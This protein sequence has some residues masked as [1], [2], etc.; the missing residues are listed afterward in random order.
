M[1]AGLHQDPLRELKRS[2]KPPS[3]KNGGSEGKGK[4][5]KEGKM[6]KE[7]GRGVEGREKGRERRGRCPIGENSGYDTA[8]YRTWKRVGRDSNPRPVDRKSGILTTRPPSHTL[9]LSAGN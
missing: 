4:G 2:P 9:V 7:W 1:A 8:T 3:R 5:E 6:E